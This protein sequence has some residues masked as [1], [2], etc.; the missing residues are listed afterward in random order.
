[1][2]VCGHDERGALKSLAVW[3]RKP[4]PRVQTKKFELNKKSPSWHR[5]VCRLNKSGYYSRSRRASA[6]A[7]L[8]HRSESYLVPGRNRDL[9]PR[10]KKVWAGGG[11]TFIEIGYEMCS[12]LIARRLNRANCQREFCSMKTL[13]LRILLAIVTSSSAHAQRSPKRFLQ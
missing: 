11:A 12:E 4:V 2:A 8:A 1:V 3:E 10:G 6:F 13:S 5:L 9:L 7:L